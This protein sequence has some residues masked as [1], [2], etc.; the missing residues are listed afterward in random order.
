[1]AKLTLEVPPEVVDAVIDVG[2]EKLLQAVIGVA[3]GRG[4]R[5]PLQRHQSRAGVLDSQR[6]GIVAESIVL[7]TILQTVVIHAQARFVH[8]SRTE[9]VGVVDGHDLA[10]SLT[11]VAIARETIAV[12]GRRLAAQILLEREIDV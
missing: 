7:R 10:P 2:G 9:H 5:K 3:Q 11:G 4:V 8:Q 6:L 12:G 1:M